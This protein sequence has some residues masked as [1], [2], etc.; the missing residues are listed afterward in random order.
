MTRR[1]PRRALALCAGGLLLLPSHPA[2]AHADPV[3]PPSAEA[4][5]AP[6][7]A[8][9]SSDGSLSDVAGVS[10]T[11]V[12]AVGQQ[13][14][15]DA[16]QGRGAITHWNG[17]A[18]TE[19]EVRNDPTGAALLRSVAVASASE[20]WAV[21]EGHEGM[22]YLARGDGSAFDRIVVDDL[23][24]G[25]WLGGVAAVPG[26][27]VA[28]GRRDG[29]PLIVTGSEGKWRLSRFDG[30]GTL[31]G[32]ALSAKGEGWAVGD[33][34]GEPLI[35]RLS[36]GQ[37]KPVPAP[38]ISGGYLRDVHVNGARRAL[39]VGG[40]YRGSGEVVPLLLSW[41][42]KKWSR[43]PVPDGDMRLYGVTGDRKNRFWISGV[44]MERPGEAFLLRYDGRTVKALRGASPLTPRTIRLQSVAY[45]PGTSTVWSV[46][47]VVDNNGRYT[48]V[49]ERFGAGAPERSRS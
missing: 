37:W 46:G 41:N 20:L 28:V 8:R 47:H 5:Q 17:S 38:D 3:R 26:K 35:M 1:L 14:I 34:E 29:Q 6:T 39:A 32:V 40:V 43:I 48:D 9:L 27:A 21:G 13:S 36:G 4:W 22:P 24:M 42:G 19:V 18:W 23:H 11:D 49:I 30:A 16:W 45:L 25:D 31:Y 10:A 2:A 44:D 15:W 12:W 7:S 33:A